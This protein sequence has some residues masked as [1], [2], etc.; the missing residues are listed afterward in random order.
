KPEIYKAFEKELTSVAGVE[1]IDIQWGLHGHAPAAAPLKPKSNIKH[2][3]LIA[4]GKGGVGK[5]TIAA[6]I[7]V[8]IARKGYQTGLMDADIYGPSIPT[9]MGITDTANVGDN[10]I[11]PHE[12]HGVK[13]ISIGFFVPE[14]QAVI[15]RGPMLHGALT[16]FINDVSWGDLDYLIVDLPPGTGDIQL[17]LSQIAPIAGC[18]IVTT[19][20]VVSLKDVAKAFGMCNNPQIKTP[21]L[22]IVENM[23]GDI[24]GRG[25]G[26][27][28]AEAH[29]TELLG[30]IPLDARVVNCSDSGIPVVVQHP[31]SDVAGSYNELAEKVINYARDNVAQGKASTPV[32]MTQSDG[33][34]GH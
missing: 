34:G 19:P 22:G 4:S 27:A 12:A 10:Q 30:T 11:K 7:A 25:G 2:I 9:I 28:F 13:V 21:V 26:K 17:T 23:T 29:D 15:W 18:V 8:S 6:N 32:K 33:C 20:Q 3:V 5:S 1:E 16:Q 14:E 24:F 31:G